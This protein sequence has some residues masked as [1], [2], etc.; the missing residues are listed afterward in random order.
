MKVLRVGVHAALGT[1]EEVLH[2]Q[3]L[4]AGAGGTL[5]GLDAADLAAIG[6]ELETLWNN[7]L[8]SEYITANKVKSLLCSALT[9]DE[10]R[11]TL[12]DY[13]TP[14]TK[15]TVIIPTVYHTNA[16]PKSGTGSGTRLPNQIAFNLT[17]LTAQRGR[18]Q[19]GRV[20]LGGLVSGILGAD[21]LFN[22]ANSRGVATKFGEQWV[23]GIAGATFTGATSL[24]LAVVSTHAHVGN[25]STNA[26]AGPSALGVGGVKAG[27]VPD[28]QRRRRG[29]RPEQSYLCWGSLPS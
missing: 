7:F 13:Q 9:Y 14:P 24:N 29:N 20:Y 15:P 25:V 4:V 8:E 11:L 27:A 21:G 22:T 6:G 12:L 1:D 19:R 3:Q 16:V 2:V 17:L 28:T 18:A 26:Y 10:M 5:E 23:A